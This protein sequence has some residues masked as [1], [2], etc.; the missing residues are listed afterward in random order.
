[1]IWNRGNLGNVKVTGSKSGKFV[2]GPYPYNRKTLEVP[3]SHK[4]CLWPN[5]ESWPWPK[6]I[7]TR[8]RTGK[9]KKV[10]LFMWKNQKFLF[11]TDCLEP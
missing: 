10:Y 11:Y 1:M 2:P 9:E 3:S 8:S 4:D 6:V 5:G 7:W